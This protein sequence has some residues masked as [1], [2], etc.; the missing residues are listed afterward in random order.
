MVTL[1]QSDPQQ[2]KS[3][4]KEATDSAAIAVRG[5]VIQ[6]KATEALR[7]PQ[8]KGDARDT[9]RRRCQSHGRQQEVMPKPQEALPKPSDAPGDD[10]AK[11]AGSDG[12]RQAVKPQ[13]WK[14]SHATPK[15]REAR[16]SRI[17]ATGN[18]GRFAK[19]T[20]NGFRGWST[21]GNKMNFF[22]GI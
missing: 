15:P 17:K 12:R 20:N 1:K 4:I 14:A 16:G 2:Q 19:A 3:S 18:H 21:R 22:Q 6:W 7:K 5:N 13:Q 11:A 9:H 10:D 8:A